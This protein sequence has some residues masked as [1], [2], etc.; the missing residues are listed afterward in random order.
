MASG[1]GGWCWSKIILGLISHMASA[2]H[3]AES[4]TPKCFLVGEYDLSVQGVRGDL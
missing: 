3:A 1:Q 2:F 4:S